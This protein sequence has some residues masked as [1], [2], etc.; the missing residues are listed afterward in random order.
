MGRPQT[1]GLYYFS[2]DVDFF[3]DTKVKIVKARYGA[4]GVLL[5]LYLLCAIYKNGYYIK[6]DDDFSFVAAD[7]LGM[8]KTKIEQIMNFLLGRS[9]FDDTLFKSDKVLTSHGIQ[10]R[11]QEGVR[12]KASKTPLTVEEKFWLL[13]ED[14]TKSF[15]KV[16]PRDNS[17]AKNPSF[18][19]KN[20]HNSEKNDI[21]KRKENKR[22]EKAVVPP[23][24]LPLSFCVQHYE[25]NIGTI[26]RYVSDSMQFWLDNGFPQELIAH[27]INEACA[28]NARNWN[29]VEKILA[30][31]KSE[32]VRSVDAFKTRK[33]QKNANQDAGQSVLGGITR[34]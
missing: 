27:A 7:D 26:S 4:D 8:E 5:Y 13:S 23:Q 30:R 11:F 20:P 32:N 34:L 15:I 31:C 33:E 16:R 29:Y 10:K 21:N 22:K 17:S 2:L 28:H 18:S 3:S 12:S 9:L 1:K 6:I 14:E 24:N 19:E 25:Q